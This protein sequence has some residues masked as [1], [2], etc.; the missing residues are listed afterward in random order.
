[1]NVFIYD[2]PIEKPKEYDLYISFNHRDMGLSGNKNYIYA[3][4]HPVVSDKFLKAIDDL[5]KFSNYEMNGES[6][7]EI[8]SFDGISLWWFYE[9]AMRMNYIKY[10]RHF[11]RLD[12]LFD[13]K[14]IATAYVDINDFILASAVKN[15]CQEKGIRVQD[16]ERKSISSVSIGRYSEYFRVGLTFLAD[17]VISRAYNTGKKSQVII[18]SYS[19]YWSRYNVIK[20]V[21]QDGIFASIQK[22]LEEDNIEYIGLEYNNE[23]LQ[24][25]LKTRLSKHKNAPGKWIPLNAYAT[26]KTMRRS[27]EISK[28]VN[29]KLSHIKF[30]NEKDAF[31]LKML[32]SHI[33]TSFFLICEIL[34]FRNALSSIEP[35][36]VLTSCEY[37]KM[38]RMAVAFGNMKHLPTVA[39]QHGIVTPKHEGYIFSKSEEVSISDAVNSRPIPKYTLL[40]GP[41]DRAILTNCSTYPENSLIIT[42]QPRYDYLYEINSSEASD[43][44]LDKIK[45]GHPL[46]V[47]TSQPD[48][49]DLE[50]TKII[51]S[52]SD[53]LDKM[54]VNLFIKP[55]P[56]ERDLSVYSPLTQRENVRLS[57]DIDIYK[58][59]N[60]CDLLITTSSTTA[61]EAAA[62]NK[63]IIVLNLSGMPDVNDY[64]TEGI[65]LGVYDAKDLPAAAKTLLENE[66]L[67]KVQRKDYITNH[68]YKIDGRSSERVAAFIKR[69]IRDPTS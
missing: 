59:L 66:E 28:I 41:R 42:G 24:D 25:Y 9:I 36:V 8:I 50:S 26:I 67:Q 51:Q 43:N 6:I 15:L 35:K 30:T 38:G 10:L 18:A 33:R 52:I 55:H 56:L 3:D 68:L 16:A 60:A 45:L 5:S 17:L 64:V 20:D 65:A 21:Q 57:K 54:P 44:F 62:L 46:I 29:Q 12:S 14:E 53:L 1:M 48:R 63:P 34:S 13:N 11:D 61:M 22:K 32:K 47:W 2:H 7:K 27:F 39:I 49:S 23:S 31:I 69:L 37:C 19:G 4:E 58:L 40:Y